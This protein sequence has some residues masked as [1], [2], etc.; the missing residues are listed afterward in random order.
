MQQG[1]AAWF[2]EFLVVVT[3]FRVKKGP[4]GAFL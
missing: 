4:G 3:Y 1:H 2:G